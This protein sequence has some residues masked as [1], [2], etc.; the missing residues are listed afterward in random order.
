MTV[1][2]ILKYPGAKALLA[3]YILRYLP[4]S[5]HYG[6]PYFGS[7]AVFFNKKPSPHEIVNDL[8][9]RLVGFFRMVRER[10]EELARLVELTPYSRAEY[11]ESYT[12]ADDPLEDARRFLV[13]SWMSHSFK[14]SGRTGWRNN[15]AVSLQPVTRLWNDVPMRIR[16]TITRLKDAEIDCV[17]AL[18]LIERYQVPDMLWYVDPPYV[19]STRKG[20]KCYRHEMTDSE[21]LTLLDALDTTPAMVV[22]SGYRSALYDDRLAHWRR[23]E[24]QATSEKGGTRTECLWMNAAL[25]RRLSNGPLFDYLETTP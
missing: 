21:H 11:Y 25:Q 6:E 15:G 20:R 22:L 2:P 1:S 5:A 3:P 7:G 14:T 19:L 9:G 17:P 12:I 13:R 10:G 18:A 24:T 23:V 8:D 16:A 4:A